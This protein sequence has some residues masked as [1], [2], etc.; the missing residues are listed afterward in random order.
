MHFV[1]KWSIKSTQPTFIRPNAR[2]GLSQGE[3]LNVESVTKIGEER[4]GLPTASLGAKNNYHWTDY[5][6]SLMALL[7]APRF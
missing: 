1:L 6:L 2:T 7:L 5:L 3:I 4:E